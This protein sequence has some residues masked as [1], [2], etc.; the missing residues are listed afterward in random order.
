MPQT[1]LNHIVIRGRTEIL[2][3]TSIQ[4]GGRNI[5]PR[6][7]LDRNSHGNS[8]RAKLNS[9]IASFRPGQENEFVYLVFTSPLDFFID[10]DKFDKGDYRL[11]TYKIMDVAAPDGVVHKIVEATVYLNKRAISSFLNKISD[12]IGR[13]TLKGNPKNQTLIANIEN[14][15]AAVIESFWQ[16]PELPFPNQNHS[17]WWEI[18][19][20]R[21]ENDDESDPI[22]PI[23]RSLE[24]SNI[25]IGRR[26]LRFPEHFVYLMRGTATQLS[27][28]ILY[29]DRLAEIRQPKETADVFTN[30]ERTDQNQ[31]IEG[32]VS[33][34]QIDRKGNEIAVCLLDTGVTTSN[35]LLANLVPDRNLDS[36]EPAW[37]K[38]DTHRQGHGTPMAG[39]AL[40]GDL[41]DILGSRDQVSIKHHLESIKLIER[42]SPHDPELYGAVT[43]EAIA[44]AEVINPTFKRLACMAVTV[45]DA[46]HKGR[47]SSWSSAIDQRLFGNV[48]DPNSNTLF[49]IS[50]GNLP[51]DE[52]I[53][54]PL[55]NSDASIHDP[56]QSFNSITVGS[57][58]LKDRLD[59][60]IYPGAEILARRG[61]MSPSNTSSDSWES[62]WCRKPDITM[63]G[64]NQAI[65]SGGVIDPESLLVLSTARGGG[66]G[67]SWLTSFGETSGATALA[68]RFGAELYSHYPFLWPETI[69]GLVVHSADWTPE[70]LGNRPINGL[71]TEQQQKLI[72]HVGYGVPNLERAKYSANNSL[73]LIAERTLRPYKLED[74]RI[75]S[76]EFHLF[77]L[78]WPSEVLQDLLATQVS[79]K[80]TLSYFIEPNPG[81]K[82]YEHAA[83][84]RS[85][86]LRFKMKGS[87]ERLNTF[88]ARVSKDMRDPSYSAEASESWILG[89]SIR[90]KGSIHK[91]IWIGTA[92]DLATRNAIAVYPVGGWW[93]TRRKHNRFINTVRYSLIMTIETPGVNTDIYTPVLNMISIDI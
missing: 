77:D 48:E 27:R 29:S 54:Y 45:E 62:D 55:A 9:A 63:E 32:L 85:H 44:R 89:N 4:S 40:Y 90:D 1:L 43:Q 19:L 30:M 93:K 46:T 82:Q 21:D 26:F 28:S 84:Y 81:N 8:I 76:N 86:G 72:R 25:Q 37:S 58:T 71:T 6:T 22:A 92:A 7:G 49:F 73:S 61:A 41:S 12:Y 17:V 52:R 66:L 60:S 57:Y 36:V 70:M 80:I 56:A 50:S 38:Q 5:V 65:Q 78:P 35:P 31:W 2:S 13:D 51:L 24:D 88:K 39:L 33:R 64:G 16:E 10:L 3:Y 74:S 23:R 18:W 11:A 14:V 42:G 47:P 20:N 83:S 87:G 59:L 75:Q 79:F 34:T 15:R 67:H 69:R 91:D 68:S 53:N